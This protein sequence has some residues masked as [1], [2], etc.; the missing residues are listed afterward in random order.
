MAAMFEE[1]LSDDEFDRRAARR[2][3]M[4]GGDSGRDASS[5]VVVVLTIWPSPLLCEWGE[6]APSTLHH[7]NLKGIH[8]M[9]CLCKKSTKIMLEFYLYSLKAAMVRRFQ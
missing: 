5:L 1:L 4:G 9:Q 7:I 8:K 3:R 2:S 6:G